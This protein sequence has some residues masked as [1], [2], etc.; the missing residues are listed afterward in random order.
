MVILPIIINS[1]IRSFRPSTLA[2]RLAAKMIACNFNLFIY[3]HSAW[4]ACPPTFLSTF[5]MTAFP[6]SVC[7]HFCLETCPP[8]CLSAFLVT[9]FPP[10]FLTDNLPVCLSVCISGRQ[11]VHLMSVCIS[12]WQKRPDCLAFFAFL[13]NSL[14]ASCLSGFLLANLSATAC[15]SAFL[16]YSLST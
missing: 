9:A 7:L 16:V 4:Q 10:A 13:F 6:T 11:P 5:L 3:L 14:F 8:T 1:K 2:V 15:L 12:H